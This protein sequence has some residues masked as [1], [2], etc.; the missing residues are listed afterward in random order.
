M[1]D[2]YTWEAKYNDGS[3]IQEWAGARYKDIDRSKLDVFNLYHVDD[4]ATP[5][6]AVNIQPGQQLIWRKRRL[7]NSLLGLLQ[8]T[9]IVGWIN[10]D[11][12]HATVIVRD[13]L[14]GKDVQRYDTNDIDIEL[15]AVHSEL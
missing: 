3:L 10:G 14:L 13:E 5:V 7:N 4:L 8:T 9:F 6:K 15:S 1:A 12:R 2:V 11:E